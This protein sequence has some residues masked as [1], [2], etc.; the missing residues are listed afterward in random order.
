MI[1]H[2]L[3]FLV[4]AGC[5]HHKELSSEAVLKGE[6]LF[7]QR[8]QKEYA[9]FLKSFF[10]HGD[11]AFAGPAFIEFKNGQ[12][13]RLAHIEPENSST[14]VYRSNGGANLEYLHHYLTSTGEETY[15][16]KFKTVFEALGTNAVHDLEVN[17]RLK[18]K[19]KNSCMNVPSR[20][21]AYSK[22]PY[23]FDF[24]LLPQETEFIRIEEPE[25]KKFAD[26]EQ[27]AISQRMIFVGMSEP[28]VKES[29]GL[30]TRYV[31]GYENVS[32]KEGYVYDFKFN[33]NQ[34]LH[35]FTRR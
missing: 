25:F 2:I 10:A 21:F 3:A 30:N 11:K 18:C 5:S 31:H 32:F 15:R 6:Y 24:S 23:T 22:D 33:F 35:Y 28:A 26:S 14:A 29:I 19:V 17:I 9:A 16:L 1:K 34:E 13:I 27:T 4:L 12:P 20:D 7:N 8:L